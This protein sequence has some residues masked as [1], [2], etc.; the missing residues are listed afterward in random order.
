MLTGEDPLPPGCLLICLNV[1][2]PHEA[3]AGDAAEPPVVYLVG[4][5]IDCRR[6]DGV[7]SLLFAMA[8][9][10]YK[11]RTY[12]HT[13]CYSAS[14]HAIGRQHRLSAARDALRK[15]GFEPLWFSDGVCCCAERRDVALQVHQMERGPMHLSVGGPF[16][17]DIAGHSREEV[18]HLAAILGRELDLAPKGW[19]LERTG[20]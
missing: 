12:A 2:L 16:G 7:E 3:L 8:F 6:A 9:R 15:L 11:L 19:V 18:T 20:R 5:Q 1:L 4:S 13:V 14:Y 10:R 17:L